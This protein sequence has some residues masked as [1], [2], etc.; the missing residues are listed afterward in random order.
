MRPSH[1]SSNSFRC[2]DMNGWRGTAET[3]HMQACSRAGKKC[4]GLLTVAVRFRPYSRTPS[5]PGE[6]P[7]PDLT[8]TKTARLRQ[9]SEVTVMRKKEAGQALIFG[10]FA[11]GLL[12][13]GLMG[14]GIDIGYI[15]YE[16]RLQQSAADS[17]ALA[18]AAEIP[19]GTSFIGAAG[20]HG[21]SLDGFTAA[22]AQTGCPPTAP[23]GTVGSIAVTINNPP[24][25]G[26]H[27]GD[28][29][30]VES[31]VA[32]VQPTFFMKALGITTQTV[33]A[34]AVA[35][36]GSGISKNCVFTLGSPTDPIE[37]ITA[38][39]SPTVNAP[40]CGI[41]DNGDLRTNGADLDVT[42]GSVGVVGTD[43]NN[44]GGG[45]TPTP[46]TGIAP[47]GDPLATLTPPAVGTPIAFR[48][49]NIIPGSTYNSISINNGTVNF[50]AGT[51]VVNGNMSIRGN[52][53]VTGTGV[54]FYITNGGSVT[55]HGTT[56]VQFSAPTSGSYEGILFYQDP[57]D[58]ST[59]TING[60]SSSF[61][62]GALYFPKAS[63]D[64]GGN[65]T[66]FNSD[67]AYTVIVSAALAVSG[68]ATI[69]INSD[70]SGLTDGSPIRSTVLVE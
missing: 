20:I 27:D 47:M 57:N 6:V 70:F 38:S 10:V 17:A 13:L 21:A 8:G 30:Y 4:S 35:F 53:T 48:S 62:Q 25:S 19:Y 26:P 11:L 65:G 61:F 46:I 55:I 60:T 31:Y 43:T 1:L 66:T 14:L 29:N 56:H 34:R 16:K 64:F 18:G 33:T 58:T 49:D 37:G 32:M 7:P 23:S 68:N 15:R 5:A 51:Y 22:S 52:S 67:A 45:I 54:T 50:P 3:E 40:S 28:S 36:W 42:A 9:F 44:G 63:L 69:S 12:L 59:A 24:C 39:G 41:D 2:K